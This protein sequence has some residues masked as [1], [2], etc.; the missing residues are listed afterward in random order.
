MNENIAGRLAEL[1]GFL[2]GHMTLSL[3]ALL[4]GLAISLPLGIAV[5]DKPRAR[6]ASLTVASIIQTIPGLALLALMVPLLGGLIGF[7]PAFIALVLYSVLPVLRNTI[8]GIREVDP[9]L[10]EAGRGMGMT[11]R[12][13]L[14]QVQLPLAAPVIIAGV[15]TATVWVVG[16]ATLSTPVG[17]P[18]L[19]DYIFM[20]LQTR[21]N[22]AILFGCVFAAVLAV[23][24]D[25][26]IRLIERAVAKGSKR[27][28]GAAAGALGVLVVLALLTPMLTPSKGPVV[29]PKAA[30]TAQTD[31]GAPPTEDFGPVV[32]G[33]KPFTEQYVL[34]SLLEQTLA[35]AGL[36]VDKRTNLGSTVLFDALKANELDVYVD[37][38][39]TVWATVMQR[40]GSG[41][42][43]SVLIEMSHELKSKHDVT[44]LGALG[45]ENAYALAMTEA[46]ANKLGIVQIGDLTAHAPKMK[47]GGDYEFFGRTEWKQVT[48]LYGLGFEKQV[49]LDSTFMYGAVDKGEVDVISSYSTDG[50]VAAFKLRVLKDPKQAFPPYDAVILLSPRATRN[51]ALVE[52]L[53]PLV[54]A[55][56]D[57]D[58][59]WA[60][61]L[62][63]VDKKSPDA[64]ATALRELLERRRAVQREPSP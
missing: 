56:S 17:A 19:G 12:Q 38:S 8:T 63:D 1:P 41:K 33:G 34:T 11:P 59:R 13:I 21:N 29:T 39:G 26:L 28:A 47:V 10:I 25:Q 23:S 22:V 53:E 42:P 9:A 20:G 62:V 3:A 14:T 24:L 50:R 32:I 15:R 52:A 35:G 27:M 54:R 61:K 46:Q 58:M 48:A 55:I 5:V 36:E 60:N 37:Y 6:E 49:S 18:S 4:C 30:Q 2:S 43:E 45:F 64:A 40:K 44:T 7:W 16:I 51:R 31:S 57:D